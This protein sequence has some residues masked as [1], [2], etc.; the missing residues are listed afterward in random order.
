[1]ARGNPYQSLKTAFE[2]GNYDPLYLLY[3][4]EQWFIDQLQRILVENG[5]APHEKDFNFDLLYGADV[6]AKAAR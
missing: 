1:M 5:V 6:D 4:E 2:K 3:G